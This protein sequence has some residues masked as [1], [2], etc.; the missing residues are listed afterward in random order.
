M[1]LLI[2]QSILKKSTCFAKTEF[3]VEL[4]YYQNRLHSV[5][6]NIKY[7]EYDIVY[8]FGIPT[9]ALDHSMV[10]ALAISYPILVVLPSRAY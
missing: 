5:T 3:Y 9:L 8:D 10:W 1:I 6:I 7:N 2:T 4:I